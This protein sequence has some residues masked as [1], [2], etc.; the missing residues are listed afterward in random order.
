[1]LI[2]PRLF[3]R[4]LYIPI[5]PVSLLPLEVKRQRSGMPTALREKKKLGSLKLTDLQLPLIWNDIVGDVEDRSIV[6]DLDVSAGPD[7]FGVGPA[8]DDP[9]EWFERRDRS[10]RPGAY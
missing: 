9:I 1:M 5:T 10:A 6:E 3:A 2:Q 4:P 7:A 8:I